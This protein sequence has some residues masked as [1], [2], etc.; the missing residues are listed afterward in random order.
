[1]QVRRP[2]VRE[3][4]ADRLLFWKGRRYV[5]QALTWLQDIFSLAHIGSGACV[6]RRNLADFNGLCFFA[7][8]NGSHAN[9]GV[10]S[11]GV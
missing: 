2:I 3:I 11:D 10:N 6:C 7:C 1:M 4:F 8:D 9:S 5:D